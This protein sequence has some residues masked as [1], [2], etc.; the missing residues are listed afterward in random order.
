[1]TAALRVR[2]RLTEVLL[3]GQCLTPVCKPTH[4]AMAITCIDYA[5][6]FAAVTDT[7]DQASTDSCASRAPQS[8]TVSL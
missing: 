6:A 3:H 4:G 5:A 7:N 1:M 2:S 8:F